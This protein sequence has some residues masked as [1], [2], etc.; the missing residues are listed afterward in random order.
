M[1]LHHPER[2]AAESKNP[3]KLSI[4][5]KPDLKAW[6]RPESVPG[7]VATGLRSRRRNSL[8]CRDDQVRFLKI[9]SITESEVER[10]RIGLLVEFAQPG[11]IVLFKNVDGAEINAKKT[12]M[13]FVRIEISKRNS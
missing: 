11:L 2:S 7:C 4:G 3:A 13:P 6:P 12:Q 10:R 5:L 9:P 1:F 8:S